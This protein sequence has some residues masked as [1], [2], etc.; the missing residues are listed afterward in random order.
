MPEVLAGVKLLSYREAAE[1][2]DVSPQS[3]R[4]A[5]TRGNLHPMR[6]LGGDSRYKY[7]LAEE[8]AWYMRRRAHPGA[9]PGP[10]PYAPRYAELLAAG[11]IVPSE[12]IPVE[13]LAAGALSAAGP[14][15]ALGAVAL[16]LVLAL[17]LIREMLA[18]RQPDARSLAQL[19]AMPGASEALR[20][21]ADAARAAGSAR[22]AAAL[23]EIAARLDSAA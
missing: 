7:L 15:L 17:P 16:A 1:L 21:E 9:D 13:Q 19:R 22:E 4:V 10:N 5:V 23:R 11:V 8:V 6:R 2:L 20:R 18:G 3:L 14:L 12:A